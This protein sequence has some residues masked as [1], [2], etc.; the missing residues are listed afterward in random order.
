MCTFVNSTI[1]LENMKQNIYFSLIAGI[2][3]FSHASVI[4]AA[5]AQKTKE[6]QDLKIYRATPTKINALIHTKLDV[7]FDYKKRYMHG[8]EWVTLKPHFLHNDDIWSS[9]SAIVVATII[10]SAFLHFSNRF[11]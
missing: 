2:I 8:K 4:P 5:Y 3:L 7:R 1:F 10:A 6:D 9:P 11:K